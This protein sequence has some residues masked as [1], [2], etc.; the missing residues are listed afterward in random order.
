MVNRL[1]SRNVDAKNNAVQHF[2]ELFIVILP[3]LKR[4]VSAEYISKKIRIK[5]SRIRAVLN[6]LFN[7]N[8]ID[9]KRCFD[10]D[11]GKYTYVWTL[12]KEK[13]KRFLKDVPAPVSNSD[14]DD[15]AV[16]DFVCT[17]CKQGYTFDAAADYSFR[18][19]KC[20]AFIDSGA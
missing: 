18:C 15:S 2:G 10:D 14:D 11:T 17:G 1:I 13:L 9:Y 20:G 5:P 6:R 7:Y 12:K 16:Y 8:L 3:Y 4:P 19:Y